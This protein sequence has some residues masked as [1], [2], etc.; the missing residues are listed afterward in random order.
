MKTAEIGCGG[1]VING[2]HIEIAIDLVDGL[3]RLA[4]GYVD[5]PAQDV[6]V[7]VVE[8][9]LDALELHVMY[10]VCACARIELDRD[11]QGPPAEPV[12]Q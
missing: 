6:V 1:L 9:L 5:L 10:L 2:G 8:Q 12:S 11:V 4:Q 7:I 3:D